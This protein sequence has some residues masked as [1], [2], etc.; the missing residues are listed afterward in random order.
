MAI[1]FRALNAPFARF[2][3]RERSQ[4]SPLAYQPRTSQKPLEATASFINCYWKIPLEIHHK[5]TLY[6]L[7]LLITHAIV[8]PL[9]T[10]LYIQTA[11]FCIDFSLK[12]CFG[13]INLYTITYK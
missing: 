7:H 5:F 6:S 9:F 3:H 8:D 1:A 13:K 12:V 2:I 4:Q 11:A 10:V